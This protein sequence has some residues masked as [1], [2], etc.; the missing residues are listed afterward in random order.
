MSIESEH[1]V[2]GLDLDSSPVAAWFLK[3]GL[4][5]SRRLPVSLEQDR[6]LVI[7][8]GGGGCAC[9][10]AATHTHGHQQV[11]SSK[12]FFICG[13]N[14]SWLTICTKFLCNWASSTVFR[15]LFTKKNYNQRG[16]GPCSGLAGITDQDI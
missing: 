13:R 6:R 7:A 15:G 16:L 10:P 14:A 12:I 4:V 1:P 3:I 9:T 8:T 11:R 2:A 5:V